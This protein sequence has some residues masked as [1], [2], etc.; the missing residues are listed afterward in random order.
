VKAQEHQLS[1]ITHPPKRHNHHHI[2]IFPHHPFPLLHLYP[3]SPIP[4]VIP[5]ATTPIR[6]YTRRARIA[7]SSALPTVADE[8]ASPMRD[9]SQ[10]EAYPTDS[11]FIEDQDKA[12]IAKCST[13]PYDSAPRVTS[14][15]AEEGRGGI[16]RLNER[17][18]L[19]EDKEGHDT[20]EVRPNEGEVAA[21]KASDDTEEM[22]TVL[23]T[24]DAATVLAGR[25]A[26]V[27]TSSGSIP[28]AGPPAAEVPTGSDVVPTAS[29][30]FAT[31]TM[32]AK[33]L[34]EQL[35][36]K[37]QR[38]SKQ[39]ARDEEIARIHAKEEHQIMIDGLDRS[40]EVISKHLAKY[41][42]AA[43]D[44]TIGERIE[45]IN[46]LVKYQD[47]HSKILQYQAQ[48]K[49]P[50][51]KKQ[52]RDF[53]MAV[54]RNNLG[55]KVKDFKGMSFKEVEAKFKTIWEQI[56]GGVFK[57]SKG[58]AAWLKRKG[59]R[60]EQESAKKQKISEEVPEEVKSSDENF[61][62]APAE[63]KLYDKCG[64]H[65]LTSKDKDIFMLVEKDYPL[66]K[67]LALVMICY[68][69]QVENYSE[70][71]DD[72]VRK[73]Y[74][75]ANSPRQQAIK[76]PLPEELSTASEDGSHCQKKRDA[77]ARKIALLSK[78]KRNCQSMKDGSYTKIDE[79][80]V[81][82]E[83][84]SSDT[85]EVRL[86]EGEVAA[87]KASDDTEEM[88]T[89]LTTMDAATVLA[90]RA[91]EVPTG[92]GSIPTAGPFVAEVPTGSDVVTTA[93]LVFATATVVTSYRRRK[94]K[95]VMVESKTLKK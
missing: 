86:D 14:H 36:R 88:A 90:G 91:A 10:G 12:T 33:E 25:A 11:G 22:A 38:R 45:L 18:K 84:L 59:I 87:K 8:P 60:S 43:A 75:I 78:I 7:Q 95:E 5:S 85:E 47:H 71:A 39:I 23:T 21:E 53:Y 55:W 4:T 72:L 2:L 32:I 35:E 68:K 94:G 56:K 57:I 19:L 77:T 89:V 64:V 79:E 74:N 80:E 30:V 66:R 3:L 17:V 20:E 41:D 82:T 6:L 46:E 67:G 31:A 58:E 50:K 37:D 9:N 27:P 49:K 92:S 29:L 26:E 52:K 70:M 76:F 15:A 16:N 13:L 62:H 63:W 51:T 73:I 1:P 81:A 24:M 48:Q 93:S 61:M 44:L 34:K 40:N 28:T 42:Q 83:R 54:I 69:L 65:Q